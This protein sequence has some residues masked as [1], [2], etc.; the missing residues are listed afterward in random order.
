MTRLEQLQVSSV[1]VDQL[2]RGLRACVHPDSGAALSDLLS[3]ASAFGALLRATIESSGDCMLLDLG[4]NCIVAGG[5][6]CPCCTA[7]RRVEAIVVEWC[8][9]TVPHDDAD[10][11]R[12]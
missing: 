8:G 5:S 12:A 9:E 11:V 6:M 4:S 1:R 3:A 2:L 10:E 7:A